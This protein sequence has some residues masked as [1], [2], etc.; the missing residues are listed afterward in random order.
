MYYCYKRHR[1]FKILAIKT[2]NTVQKKKKLKKC[3]VNPNMSKKFKIKE[4]Q[5]NS[6]WDI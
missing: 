1:H 4:R 3:A 2:L 6:T 5:G